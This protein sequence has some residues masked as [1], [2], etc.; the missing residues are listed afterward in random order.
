MNK[1]L[2]QVVGLKS[3]CAAYMST[4]VTEAF[5]T[6]ADRRGFTLLAKPTEEFVEGKELSILLGHNVIKLALANTRCSTAGQF[7]FNDSCNCVNK[8]NLLGPFST[9]C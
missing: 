3:F 6:Q 7:C 2:E 1:S 8:A 4:V 5:M 9:T